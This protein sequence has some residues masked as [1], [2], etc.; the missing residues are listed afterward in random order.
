ML[1]TVIYPMANRLLLQP[2]GRLTRGM[3]LGV[4]A[5]VQDDKGRYLVVRQSYTKGWIFPGGGVERG[6]DP[7]SAVRREVMEETGIRLNGDLGLFGLYSNHANY[8]GDYVAV[9]RAPDFEQGNW[10]PGMEI[11]HREF[12]LPDDIAR[13]CPPAML[14]R[15]RELTGKIDVAA[16]W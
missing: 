8:P 16:I 10:Q 11:T 2:M 3:T 15:L 14:R 5:I 4:R 9:Y 6:E 13:D 7:V 1:K 12:L